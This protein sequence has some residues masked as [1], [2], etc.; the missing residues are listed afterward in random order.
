MNEQQIKDAFTYGAGEITAS[1][2]LWA[3]IEREAA[4]RRPAPWRKV[5]LAAAGL[6]LA[7]CL[8]LAASPAVRAAAGTLV[9]LFTTVWQGQVGG[10]DASV[11]WADVNQREALEASGMQFFE[12][13]ETLVASPEEAK[14]RVGFRPVLAD[15][16]EASLEALFVQSIGGDMFRVAGARYRIGGKLF[17]V[18]TS[19]MYARLQDGTLRFLPFTTLET[20]FVIGPDRAPTGT[21][22]VELASGVEAMCIDFKQ[23]ADTWCGWLYEG[24]QVHVT[25]PDAALVVELARSAVR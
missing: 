12:Y 19:A 6:V 10:T 11:R 20:T 22:T 9:H 23:G 17:H 16:P 13:Q 21:R 4:A 18:G 25:G 3:R 5:W 14:A 24:L 7:L 2:E 8:S 15:H 1:D